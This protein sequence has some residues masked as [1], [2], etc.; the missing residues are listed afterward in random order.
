MNM[1]TIGLE[2][3]LQ[4]IIQVALYRKTITAEQ[5][6]KQALYRYLHEEQVV[7]DEEVASEYGED[8]IVG[9]FD[10]GDPFLS[11]KSEEILHTIFNAN[12]AVVQS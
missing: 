11:E 1:L 2:D 10:L 3:E 8:S 12:K 9:M 4:Q 7:E 5:L 6:V